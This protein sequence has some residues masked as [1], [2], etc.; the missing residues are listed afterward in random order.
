MSTTASS[1]SQQKD[2]NGNQYASSEA[3]SSFVGFANLPNQ[4]H[5]KIAK[6]GFE[7]TLM[8]VGESGLG[9]ATL[10]NSL[11]LTD[12]YPERHI[13]TA[14]GVKIEASTVEIEERGVK[15]RLTVVDTPG[16]G[17]SIN[18]TDCYKSIINYIDNQFER[19]L[20]D[21]SGLNRRNISDNRV[22]C[23]FYF[24]SS[25]TR[26]LKPLD[27]ECM[28]QLHHKVNIVPIIA[29]ADALT[30][31]ELS[32]M[33]QNILEQIRDHHIQ[34]YQIPECDS[35]E[36]EEFKEQNRKLKNAVPFAVI[37]SAQTL[38]VKGKKVRGRMY[39]WG[40][41]EVENADH[42]DFIKLR[43]MLITHMQ[44]LQEVTHEIHYENYRSEKL[45]PKNK[46]LRTNDT[47]VDEQQKKLIKEKDDELRRMQD[48]LTK[49]QGQ[50]AEKQQLATPTLTAICWT[51]TN[52][53]LSWTS[54]IYRSIQLYELGY[55]LMNDR[56]KYLL[57]KRARRNMQIDQQHPIQQG[58]LF[59]SRPDF[60]D[61]V[62]VHHDILR[63]H[64]TC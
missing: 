29:K 54:N 36:D 11:F 47:D 42:C 34:I 2:T 28:K 3:T 60:S 33:K 43:T 12:L 14:Q 16:Y 44:D 7:F 23:L 63:S 38:E 10:I 4:V 24:I 17:D 13:P 52:L 19:Y 21:E 53:V 31:D 15:V 59:F 18:T 39:P 48:M 35:D 30:P 40:L 64:S 50:L 5:R 45:Q 57:Y 46:Q 26:G 8:V 27:I 9:K 25:F 22:H 37:S 32:Q 55:M 6:R 49:M 62:N 20:N 61:E 51:S 56:I 41:V 1:R 58:L